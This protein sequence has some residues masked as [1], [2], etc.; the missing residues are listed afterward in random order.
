MTRF[1]EQKHHELF[2]QKNTIPRGLNSNNF[3]AE[4]YYR[5]GTGLIVCT[6]VAGIVALKNLV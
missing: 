3:G 4:L 2:E 5:K 1:V 6:I